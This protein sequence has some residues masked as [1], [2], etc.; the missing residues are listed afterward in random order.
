[1]QRGVLE[2]YGLGVPTD[3]ETLSIGK[4]E[5]LEAAFG[6][7]SF[8]SDLQQRCVHAVLRP[9][10]CHFSIDTVPCPNKTFLEARLRA[11]TL[12]D[13]SCPNLAVSFIFRSR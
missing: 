11:Q 2:P 3:A 9:E 6:R 1:M 10:R 13:R 4:Q 8:C 7:V 5:S 12:R